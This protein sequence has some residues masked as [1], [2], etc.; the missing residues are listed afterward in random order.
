VL[1]GALLLDDSIDG[2]LTALDVLLGVVPSASGVGGGDG[3]ADSADQ[4]SGEHSSDGSGSEEDSDGQGG[5]ED[6]DGREEH[7]VEGGGGGD[8]DT[9][10]VVGS[11]GAGLDVWVLLELSSDFLDHFEG[12]HADGL[13]GQG[14]E[15]V[16]KHGSDEQ[17]GEDQGGVD[18]DSGGGDGSVVLEV[19]G[20]GDVG[21]EQGQRDEGCGVCM[22]ISSAN[23]GGAWDNAKKYIESGQFTIDGVVKKKG[24]NEHK[25]AVI[26]DTV[27]DPLKD[28]SGPSL[29]ILIKLSAIFSLIFVNFFDQTAFLQ[30]TLAPTSV[31]CSA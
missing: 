26:G 19:L 10:L 21:A 20:S 15:G 14:G 23:A 27:G 9:L 13:H 8:G 6:D 25:A 7:L 4:D 18:V 5:S 24:S 16:R 3:H 28:T 22:A 30:C 31:G 17:A 29:N 2:E 1:V 12:G 11:G